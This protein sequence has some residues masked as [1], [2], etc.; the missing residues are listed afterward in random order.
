[1]FAEFHRS[2]FYFENFHAR[3]FPVPQT[4]I[5]FSET[6]LTDETTSYKEEEEEEEEDVHNILMQLQKCGNARCCD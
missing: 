5:F 6:V 1:M 3:I 4:D 2:A